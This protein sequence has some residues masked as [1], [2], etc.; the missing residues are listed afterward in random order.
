[1]FI[2]K[3]KSRNSTCFQI[4]YKKNKRFKLVKHIGC[5]QEPEEIEALKLKAKNLLQKLKFKDQLSFLDKETSLKA[6]LASWKITGFHQVFG[7]VYDRIGF[8]DNLLRDLVVARIAHPRSKLAT[9][10][11]LDQRLGIPVGKDTVYRFLDTL[12]KKKLTQIAF[13]F[14]YKRN[15]QKLTLVFYDVTTLY[16]ET[17]KEDDLR[18]KGYSKDHRSD[19]PQ[20][21]IGLFVDRDGYPFDFDFFEGKKFEGHTLPEMINHLKQK[22]SF[23]Q[24]TVVADAGM[25]SESNLAF[26]DSQNIGYIVGAR[27]K[28]L[29]G[30]CKERLV[31]IDYD[32]QS[33]WETNYARRR[34]LIHYSP[35]RAQKD[36]KRRERKIRKLK[37]RLQKGQTLVRKSKYIKLTRKNKIVGIDKKK[38]DEDTQFDG[39]KGYFTNTQLSAKKVINNYHDLWQ[40]ERA[41]RM[42][43]YD[44]RERPIYHSKPERIKSH[45]LLCFVSLLVMRETERIL[46]QQDCSLK[47]A[48]RLLQQVGEGEV[49]VGKVKVP[50]ESELS[51]KT[52]LI[53]DLFV[54]H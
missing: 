16:F 4:G 31:N 48:I 29:P 6:K 36:Q 5:S 23:Q 1:M 2:R 47:K 44:L 26:L 9:V 17:P 20:I 39:L 42:S 21:L 38:I 12:D 10:Y 49:Q 45:L 19:M 53:L 24:L 11:Y 25:L 35:K 32:K 8:P 51:I 13:N 3:V 43:K 33:V 14:V 7:S 46:K 27:L 41:F 54:G 34:L 37:V 52:Q 18:Q 40:V 22:Y 28:N 15:S 50:L 30:K